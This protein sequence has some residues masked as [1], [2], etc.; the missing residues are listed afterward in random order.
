MY[1]DYPY[2]I[3]DIY[4]AAI[5]A[6]EPIKIGDVTYQEDDVILLFDSIQQVNFQE[7]TSTVAASGGF[8]NAPLVMWETT[9][10]VDCA[11]QIGKISKKGYGLLN[12][13]ILGQKK[14]YQLIRQFEEV[15]SDENGVIQ[16]KHSPFLDKPI[17]VMICINGVTDNKILDYQLEDSTL[18][19]EEKPNT[20]FLIDYWYLENV[21]GQ[22]IKIG[23]KLLNGFFKFVGKFYYSDEEGSSCKTAIIEI[24]K[25]SIV[26]NFN[27]SFGRNAN[28]LISTLM[29]RAIPSGNRDNSST[30]KIIYLDKDIDGDF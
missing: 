29:F 12:K 30:M 20:N 26:G 28:P 17:N 24:P 23:Q 13:A 7:I 19:I 22:T 27:I 16:L 14:A 2:M 9:N 25:I 4:S 1:N 11:L 8:N 6:T 3:K 15:Q 10:E 5:L 21:S 18:T